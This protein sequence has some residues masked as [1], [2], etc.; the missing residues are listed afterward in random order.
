MIGLLFSGL[1]GVGDASRARRHPANRPRLEQARSEWFV[2]V[3]SGN[4]LAVPA[5]LVPMESICSSF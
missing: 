3:V 4:S 5:P 1:A 2:R